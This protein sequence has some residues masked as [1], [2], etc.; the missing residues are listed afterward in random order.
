MG[1]LGGLRESIGGAPHGGPA[2]SA[3]TPSGELAQ[4]HFVLQERR[5]AHLGEINLAA[6]EPFLRGLLFT[7]GTVTRTLEVQALSPVS[8]EVADQTDS[9]VSGQIAEYLEVP[10]GT[11]S[12]RRRVLIGTGEPMEPAI[13]AESQILPTRLPPGF[14]GVLQGAPDGI[15]ESLQQVELESWREL[16]WFGVDSHP[17]WSGVDSDL[18]S[19]VVTR[20]YR[21]ITGGLPAL[22]ISESFSV[23]LRDGTYYLNCVNSHSD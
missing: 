2:T 3:L 8:V 23:T 19:P 11:E 17:A 10:S 6:L 22:L 5:P 13:W 4:R 18:S 14:L 12:V 21:V 7:D 16:L 15:G 20:L 9:A 1:D